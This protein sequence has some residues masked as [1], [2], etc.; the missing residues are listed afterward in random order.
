MIKRFSVLLLVISF[1]CLSSLTLQEAKSL[2][3]KNNLELSSADYEQKKAKKQYLQAW[4]QALLQ[5][6]LEAGYNY[7]KSEY[8]DP[9]DDFVEGIRSFQKAVPKMVDEDDRAL[10]NEIID[11]QDANNPDEKQTDFAYGIKATQIISLKVPMG[12][13]MMGDVADISKIK[14][15]LKKQEVLFTVSKYYYTLLLASQKFGIQKQALEIAQQNFEQVQSM[16]KNGL[17][18]QYDFLRA[19]LEV[20]K[21]KPELEQSDKNLVLARQTFSNY[22]RWEKQKKLEITDSLREPKIEIGS[23]DEAIQTAS[24]ERKELRMV[25]IAT[26]IKKKDYR[27]EQLSFLPDF[28]ANFEY[29]MFSQVY[30]NRMETENMGNYWQVT[31]GASM[32]IFT[33]FARWNKVAVKNYALKQTRAEELNTQD[34]VKLDVQ[35]SYYTLIQSQKSWQSQ[36]ENLALAKKAFSIAQGRYENGISTQ[37][38][39]LDATLQQNVAKLGYLNSVYEY[40]IAWESYKMAIGD[41]L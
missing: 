6:D 41:E 10:G 20:T 7:K 21:Q 9:S 37:L 15:E 4:G 40:I 2:A 24:K 31:L 32:P 1:S 25:E 19:R 8:P 34:L 28:Q 33:S 23:L 22:V 26:T 14:A 16:Y 27:T 30:E 29:K 35:N 3:L 17:V 36:K 39:Y 5:V 12:V 38:E 13:S 18:S 11:L